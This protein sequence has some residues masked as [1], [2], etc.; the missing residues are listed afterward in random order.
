M[1][2]DHTDDRFPS[3]PLGIHEGP[4]KIL[5]GTDHPDHADA[6]RP[7]SSFTGISCGPI[8]LHIVLTESAPEQ[9]HTLQSFTDT[10]QQQQ[11]SYNIAFQC[12][13]T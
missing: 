6:W 3:R 13:I 12:N 7:Y 11:T 2:R 5:A 4:Q 8:Y 10:L 9:R 1:W